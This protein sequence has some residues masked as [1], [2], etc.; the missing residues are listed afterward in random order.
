MLGKNYLIT[1]SLVLY[2]SNLNDLD[3]V[4]QSVLNSDID[5]LFIIDN[6]PTNKL[7]SHIASFNSDRL[8]YCYGQGNIGF[9]RANNIGI[10]NALAKGSKYHIILNPDIVFDSRVI[11][12]LERFMSSHLDVGLI[13]PRV[14]YPNGD[15]QYLCKLLPSPIDI[16]GRRLLPSKWIQKRNNK[17]EMHFFGY[18]KVWNCPVLSGCFMF[19]R[20]SALQDV[21]M[22]DDRFFMYFE[23]FDL[24]RRIHVKYKTLYYPFV[25]IVHNHAAEHR[26]NKMLLKESIKSA[27]KYFN[28]WG[29]FIDSER[30]RINK[31]ALN[32]NFNHLKL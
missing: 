32:N 26:T 4:L 9:G 24:M 11:S 14:E 12:E 25:T 1:A 13:L 31:N 28:K 15:L 20:T 18:D 7:A 22:F 16:F 8:E 23:D 2:K 10:N 27:I 17:Y 5:K 19:L 3:N 6:S 29:W 21:G 30:K